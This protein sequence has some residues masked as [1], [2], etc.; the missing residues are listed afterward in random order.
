M[1]LASVGQ[2]L[3]IAWKEFFRLAC[4]GPP[5]YQVDDRASAIARAKEILATAKLMITDVNQHASALPE[6]G[7]QLLTEQYAK[8]HNAS[9]ETALKQLLHKEQLSQI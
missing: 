3:Q 5:E 2:T 4:G 1:T 8:E 6:N 7:L 9:K